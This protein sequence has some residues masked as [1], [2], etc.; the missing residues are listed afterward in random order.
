MHDSECMSTSRRFTLAAVALVTL[1]MPTP[2][3]ANVSNGTFSSSL[4]QAATWRAGTDPTSRWFADS[5]TVQN[6]VATLAPVSGT[7][8]MIQALPITTAGTYTLTYRTRCTG[9]QNQDN[10]VHALVV[11][12]GTT[13][14]L[15][16]NG[17]P[18]NINQ[19]GV[20]SAGR[21]QTS[22]AAAQS[23][24]AR[25]FTF[26][27]TSADVTAKS[28]LVIAFTASCSA[29]QFIEFDDVAC[30]VPR[31]STSGGINTEWF[32]APSGINSLSSVNWSSPVLTTS[33]ESIHWPNTSNR[34]HP[35]MPADL[36]AIRATATIDVPRDG[37]W[38]F[39]LGS[40][41]G[42]RLTIDG[43]VRINADAPQSFTT[44]SASVALTKGTH[45]LEV[46]FY[47]RTGNA[48][49]ILSWRGPGY[50]AAEIIP[51]T[52]FAPSSPT[53]TRTR[54]TRWQEISGE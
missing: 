51:A 53:P 38:T 12:P 13:L 28:F 47:E 17:I 26:A 24:T 20:R 1:I 32:N 19:S 42:S 41:D 46:L 52:A 9:T 33:E 11:T 35:A 49:L 5:L 16:N 8:S 44:R 14:S 39:S 25:S 3:S 43:V 31:A 54:V 10:I 45:T 40:D 36:F 48:G 2:S 7:R 21:L 23:W 6:G 50:P 18:W 29:S 22:G 30:D 15:G 27:I 4:T 37:L 34:W